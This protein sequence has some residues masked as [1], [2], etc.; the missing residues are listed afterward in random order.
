M[1]SSCAGSTVAMDLCGKVQQ[2][3]APTLSLSAAFFG[4]MPS[5]LLMS[6]F[7]FLLSSSVYNTKMV[8]FKLIHV[9]KCLFQ[10]CLSWINQDC[11]GL[12]RS[13]GVGFF[14]LFFCFSTF[15][16]IPV[17]I[18]EFPNKQ[19]KFSSLPLYCVTIY[20]RELKQK[21]SSC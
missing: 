8:L 2:F 19:L 4:E 6:I 12:K 7:V 1:Y 14:G 21:W 10:N 17:S 20:V 11:L 18:F 9:A 15:M 3:F 5:G 13:F 16:Q